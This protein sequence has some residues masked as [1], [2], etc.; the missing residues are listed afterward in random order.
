MATHQT[1]HQRGSGP[2][3]RF[4]SSWRFV[5]ILLLVAAH[6]FTL[7]NCNL[8]N[9]LADDFFYYLK[10]SDNFVAGSG[11]SFCRPI[12]TNGYQPFWQLV[13]IIAAWLQQHAGWSALTTTYLAGLL[14]SLGSVYL[15]A[16]QADAESPEIAIAALIAGGTSY[17]ITT[18]GMET[19][20]LILFVSLLMINI[21]KG[22][23]SWPFLGVVLFACFLC[24]I[25]S[26]IYLL[27]VLT[28]LMRRQ[29]RTH[30]KALATTGILIGIY[31]GINVYFY[32]LP[33]PVSGMAK[34]GL[35]LSLHLQTFESLISN[36]RPT[37]L[38][39]WG[40]LL[41]AASIYFSPARRTLVLVSGSAVLLFYILNAFRSDYQIWPWYLY[42][43]VLHGVVVFLYPV[44]EAQT[45]RRQTLWLLAM[46]TL[47]LATV[48]IVRQAHGYYA[49]RHLDNG[50]VATAKFVKQALQGMNV[51]R[52]AMGDRAGAVG[53]ITGKDLV[54]LEGLV[55]DK[56][57]L[58]YLKGPFDLHAVLDRYKPDVYVATNPERIPG[59][60]CYFTREPLQAADRV[61]KNK[62]CF[63][64]L[65]TYMQPDGITE[66]VIFNLIARTPK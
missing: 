13:V 42:P 48:S 57:Y 43:F 23:T 55:M 66:T 58:T 63:P 1:S 2:L 33:V 40:L 18:M 52:I 10:I 27:P 12:L 6:A 37:S 30:I 60:D 51:Q 25:D 31:A 44:D 5:I 4:A 59:G 46:V 38:M 61:A 11:T 9:I 20:A 41:T 3:E 45:A 53:Y 16:W 8:E 22:S 24:R 35:T 56:S 34:N 21:R 50:I 19:T 29:V 47:A 17:S 28:Y 15:I 32:G 36:S 64:V 26:M 54:Q 7:L 62:I 49:Q 65:A 39:L 14:F